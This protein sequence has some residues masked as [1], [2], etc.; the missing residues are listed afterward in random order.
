V[1]LDDT[2]MNVLTPATNFGS[3]NGAGGHWPLTGG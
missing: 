1:K 2:R 3:E